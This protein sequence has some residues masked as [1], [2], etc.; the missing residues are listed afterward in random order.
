[1]ATVFGIVRQS[2]GHIWV[3][4]EP[5]QGT[6]FKLYFPRSD[7]PSDEHTLSRPPAATL[8]G[9]ETI[10]LVEDDEQVR[11]LA[12]AVLN[13]SGYHVLDAANAGDALLICESFTATIHLMVTDVVM[14]RITGRAL[15]ERLRPL[16][17]EM[18]VLYMSGYASH[19]IVRHG[20]LDADIAF[21]QKPI[22][23]DALLLKVRQTLGGG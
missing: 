20:I 17:P 19:S 6:S 18:K 11:G 16:R 9:S 13:R 14:P 8:R 22:T 3:Y 5:N 10:L 2:G 15:A 12:R 4:G 23:P 7:A 21:L 1:L